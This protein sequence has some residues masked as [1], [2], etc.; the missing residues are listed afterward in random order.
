MT[1]RHI[2]IAASLAC[3]VTAVAL[4]LLPRWLRSPGRGNIILISVD[5]LRPDHLGCYGYGKNTSPAVD[6][7]AKDA[8]L[9]ENCFAQAP[10]TRP[11][12]ASFLSGFFPHECKVTFNSDNLPP[13]VKTIAEHLKGRGYRTMA[14]SSNFVLGPGSGFDQGFDVFDNTLDDLELVRRVPERVAANTTDAAIGL[15]ESAGDRFF[16]WVH[17]QDPHGPYTPPPPFDTAFLDPARQTRKIPLNSTL[18]GIG[19]IPWY[20]WQGNE[21]DYGFYVARY[22]GEIGY[23]DEHI[24]RL[25]QALK[26]KGLYDGAL[27]IF[28]S[29]HGEGMGEHDYFFAHGEFVYNNLARVPLVIRQAKAL[30]GRRSD[31]AQ[32]LDIVPTILRYAGMKP[33]SNLRGRNLLGA[34]LSPTPILCEMDGKYS[35]IENGIK[36]IAHVEER[37][38]M[39]FDLRADMDEQ[40]DLI[41]DQSYEGYIK[42]LLTQIDDFIAED[43]IKGAVA[44]PADLSDEDKEKLKT[45]GYTH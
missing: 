22:D 43:R 27:I 25:L 6:A 36:V 9:F 1:K 41:T 40:R 4:V 3:V 7:F 2:I 30:P 45:L 28:T 26:D 13:Q 37:E 15:L 16:L 24:G 29:D 17:Y 35:M 42:P 32:L 14:V 5:T 18:S 12:C 34:A 23:T 20:Q 31:Y 39:L 21:D 33:G 8:V 10:T 44:A 19:G 38:F 11:S